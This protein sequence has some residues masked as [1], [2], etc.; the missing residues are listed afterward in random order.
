MAAAQMRV[1]ADSIDD[2]RTDL[3]YGSLDSGQEQVDET[4]AKIDSTLADLE[5]ALLTLATLD[6][7]AGG[8]DDE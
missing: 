3:E 6:A 8:V 7:V 4:V 2:A 1:A 5:E